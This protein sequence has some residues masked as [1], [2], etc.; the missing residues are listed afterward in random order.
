MTT[1]AGSCIPQYLLA[2]EKN[3]K[4]TKCNTAFFEDLACMRQ[5]WNFWSRVNYQ[6]MFAHTRIRFGHLRAQVA[7]TM[8]R[9]F[10]IRCFM[11]DLRKPMYTSSQ[12][13]R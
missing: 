11:Q 7:Y 13:E 1:A 4:M 10:A 6:E 12:V 3:Y 2:R 8:S 5:K 9:D